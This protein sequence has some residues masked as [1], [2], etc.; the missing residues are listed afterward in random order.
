MRMKSLLYV[1]FKN[2]IKFYK[3]FRKVLIYLKYLN[4]K[5]YHEG[6]MYWY[7]LIFLRIIMMNVCVSKSF[8]VRM[9]PFSI[10]IDERLI[11][12]FLIICYVVALTLLHH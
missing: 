5:N 1:N 2:V 6:F 4:V 3:H 11:F 12:V 8:D 10:R 9:S 7:R